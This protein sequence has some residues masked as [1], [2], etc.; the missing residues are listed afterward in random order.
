MNDN[1]LIQ[2]NQITMLRVLA[3]VVKHLRVEDHASLYDVLT[4]RADATEA[5]LNAKLTP[6]VERPWVQPATQEREG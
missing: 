1:D 6:A 2:S 4:R 3:R 5:F